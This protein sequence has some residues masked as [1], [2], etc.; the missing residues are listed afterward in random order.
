MKKYRDF[1]EYMY[2]N[3]YNQIWKALEP[4]IVCQKGSFES[5]SLYDIRYVYLSDFNVSG[6]T[7]KDLGNDWIEIRT[8]I[9]SVVVVSGR[10]RYG[11]ETDAISRSYNVF[12]RRC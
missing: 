9:D 3:Y 1:K 10:T 5:D 7:F 8:T 12:L 6:V 11:N 2:E 4:V